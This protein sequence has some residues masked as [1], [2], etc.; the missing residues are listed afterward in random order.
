MPRQIDRSE[1][2]LVGAVLRLDGE[3]ACSATAQTASFACSA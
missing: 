1:Q 2:G 3:S